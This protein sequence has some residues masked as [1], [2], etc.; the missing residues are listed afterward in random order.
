MAVSVA[1]AV[2]TGHL[3]FATLRGEFE[4]K[5]YVRSLPKKRLWGGCV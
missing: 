1:F 5:G 2:A 3:N 4:K